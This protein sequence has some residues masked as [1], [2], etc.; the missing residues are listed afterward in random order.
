[1]NHELQNVISGKVEVRNGKF[2]QAV[3]NYLRKS[4]GASSLV[5][6][7]KHFKEKEAGFIKEF[8]QKN[9]CWVLDIDISNYVS[10]G[11]E[12]K[13]YLQDNKT[14]LKLNDTIYYETWEDYFVNLLL[15]NYFFEDTS[16]RLKGFYCFEETLYALVEQPFV[17]ANEKTDLEQV[18]LFLSSNGFVNHRNNDYFN[19]ELGIILE[20]LH[21]ENVLT[22]N[23]VLHFIDTVFYISSSF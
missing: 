15:H 12:Q 6:N 18:K 16:Y 7:A 14:V 11:A 23:G 1:M 21:D 22:Q 8:A 13:V 9:K 19:A 10:E 5:K 4:K 17:V 20:D 3:A 2:I